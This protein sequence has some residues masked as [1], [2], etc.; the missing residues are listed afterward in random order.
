MKNFKF[1]NKIISNKTK[2]YIIVEACVN[3][4]GDFNIAKKMV[5]AA[6]KSG[7]DAVKI[8][9]YTPETMTIESD[10]PDFFINDGLWKDKSLFELYGEA[11]TPF[12]WHSE[13]FLF[14]K[15]NGY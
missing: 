14:A 9:T 7:V 11:F 8:Q 2:P 3:H 6:K 5:L 4:Q 1:G 15:K 10:N 13:L 12:E